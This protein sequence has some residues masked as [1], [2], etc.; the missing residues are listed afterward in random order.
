MRNG[1][2]IFFEINK[3]DISKREISL[4]KGFGDEQW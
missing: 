3:L 1:A 4:R 2:L